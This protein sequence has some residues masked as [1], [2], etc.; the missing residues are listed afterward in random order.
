[1]EAMATEIAE[2]N[3]ADYANY[4]EYMAKIL[5]IREKY[6]D[7]IAYATSMIQESLDDSANIYNTYLQDYA[8]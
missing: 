2:L 5:Q 8:N 7:E 6:A 3:P 1:M 4:D